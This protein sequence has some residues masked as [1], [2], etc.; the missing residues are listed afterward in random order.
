M[1]TD[2]DL[3]LTPLEGETRTLGPGDIYL[4]PGDVPHSVQGG[5][6]PSLTLDVF[7]PLRED[8]LPNP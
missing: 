1:A 8:Y 6:E 2:L 5:E 4:I 7:T 3:E